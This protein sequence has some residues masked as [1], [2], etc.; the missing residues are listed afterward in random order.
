MNGNPYGRKF[1]RSCLFL[2]SGKPVAMRMLLLA[3]EVNFRMHPDD[4]DTEMNCWKRDVSLLEKLVAY[5]S[6]LCVI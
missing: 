4:N 5:N 1:L 3:V 6:L 2:N